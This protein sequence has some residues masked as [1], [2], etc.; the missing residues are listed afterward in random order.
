M[1]MKT[2]AEKAET[3]ALE[4][5]HQLEAKKASQQGI[6]AADFS[7]AIQRAERAEA[8]CVYSTYILYLKRMKMC[9]FMFVC[10]LAQSLILLVFLL[11]H[12]PLFHCGFPD[13]QR[14]RVISI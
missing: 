10:N 4:L 12:F 9:S 13:H 8:R 2:R 6:S 14:N 3:R 7:L 1:N 5:M 11:S